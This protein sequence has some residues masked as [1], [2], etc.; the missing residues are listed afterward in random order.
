MINAFVDCDI[1]IDLLTRREPHFFESARFFQQY[2]KGKISLYSSPLAIANVHYIVRKSLGNEKTKVVIKKLLKII[3]ITD[4]S[5][6]ILKLALNSD[7][8]DFEDAIQS[9]SAIPAKC[10]Y[11]VTRN[12]KDFKESKIPAITPAEINTILDNSND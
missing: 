4:L 9:F 10:S 2:E 5:E 6:K 8:K 1:I 11:I 3:S 7:F 12:I